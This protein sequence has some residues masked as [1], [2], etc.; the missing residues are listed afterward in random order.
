VAYDDWRQV[1]HLVIFPRPQ[2]CLVLLLSSSS[3]SE[4][5]CLVVGG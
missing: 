2:P 5:R 3:E 1:V 4:L